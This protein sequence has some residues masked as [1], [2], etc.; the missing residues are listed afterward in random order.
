MLGMTPKAGFVSFPGVCVRYHTEGLGPIVSGPSAILIGHT[1]GI[2]DLGKQS[3]SADL[4]VSPARTD[5]LVPTSPGAAHS[6]RQGEGGASCL[7]C[8]NVDENAARWTSSVCFSL[9]SHLRL[10]LPVLQV[11]LKQAD[12]NPNSF[13][14]LTIFSLQMHDMLNT[15]T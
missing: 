10:S 9:D 6:H 5:Q 14:K 13:F 8:V 12:C 3:S 4:A 11:K 2:V 15:K 1:G 7:P